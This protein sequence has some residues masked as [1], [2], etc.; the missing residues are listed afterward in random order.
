MKIDSKQTA[1]QRTRLPDFMSQA[2]FGHGSIVYSNVV[3]GQ[4]SIG[5][6][7]RPSYVTIYG[8]MHAHR[9]QGR[10]DHHQWGQMGVDRSYKSTPG[11]ISR[12]QHYQTATSKLYPIVCSERV[13]WIKWRAHRLEVLVC[14]LCLAAQACQG[15]TCVQGEKGGHS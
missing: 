10:P 12:H 5:S 3:M 14:C 6:A 13:R 9:F 15:R 11:A 2:C 1:N 7:A 4:A 8:D